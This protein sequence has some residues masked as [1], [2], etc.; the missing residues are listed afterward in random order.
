M[1]GV[2]GTLASLQWAL[3][4]DNWFNLLFLDC[5]EIAA[6]LA[7]GTRPGYNYVF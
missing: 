2:A 1:D 7:L 4:E 6:E 5:P 3:R